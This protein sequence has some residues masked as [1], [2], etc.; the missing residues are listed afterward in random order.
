MPQSQP[1]IHKRARGTSFL[2][3]KQ[4]LTHRRST[5]SIEKWFCQMP[6]T[7]WK[8]KGTEQ[9]AWGPVLLQRGT[10]GDHW[11]RLPSRPPLANIWGLQVVTEKFSY[12]LFRPFIYSRHHR[13]QNEAYQGGIMKVKNAVD[14]LCFYLYTRG[15]TMQKLLCVCSAGHQIL[16]SILEG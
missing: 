14:K 11:E 6:G 13:Y 10:Q 4:M 8:Q 9:Q 3:L 7:E 2:G 1:T 16:G 12:I 5:L 15:G